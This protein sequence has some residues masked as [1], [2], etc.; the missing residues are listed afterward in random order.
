[1]A[2]SGDYIKISMQWRV[3]HSARNSCNCNNCCAHPFR[4][5]G[6][7]IHVFVS[8]GRRYDHQAVVP[9][10]ALYLN[11]TSGCRR[12]SDDVTWMH[13]DSGDT[14]SWR[15]VDLLTDDGYI[16]S[17]DGGL[18]ILRVDSL[19]HRG[20]F[21]CTDRTTDTRRVIVEHHITMSGQCQS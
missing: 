15:P 14:S 10:M 16:V 8:S 11:C 19:R 18:V 7:F 9:G 6:T 4:V 3:E 12:S 1:M 17:R 20:T 2:P 13:S 5:H 21:Y